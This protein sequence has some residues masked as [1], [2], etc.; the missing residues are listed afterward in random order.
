VR[1]VGGE[2]RGR[3]IQAPA[4]RA[5]RPTSDRVR[6]AIFDV[7]GSLCIRGETRLQGASVLDLFAGS[8][9]L[10]LEALS[11][12]AGDCTFVENATPA[13]R[14]LRANLKALGCAPERA[15]VVCRDARLALRAD[16]GAGSTYT[17]VLVDAPYAELQHFEADL[18]H[19]L[20]SLLT[21]DGVAV[22]ESAKGY[23]VRLPLRVAGSK[24]YGDTAVTFFR[25]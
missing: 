6:E 17:L 7:I 1:I 3:R 20:E 14:A 9:A 5:S 24:R 22:V 12:G 18:G 19:H 25:R 8:G 10:G 21:A 4:G 23:A 16:A 15:R 2:W 13:V 11:R